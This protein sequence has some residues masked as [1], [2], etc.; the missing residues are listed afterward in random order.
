MDGGTPIDNTQTLNAALSTA[1]GDEA[2]TLNGKINLELISGGVALGGDGVQSITVMGG[3]AG[4]EIHSSGNATAYI[5]A[6][7]G[8]ITFKNIVFTG[9]SVQVP[10]NGRGGLSHFM[11]GG[12]VYFENCTFN[13]GVYI[14]EHADARG[15]NTIA[16]FKSCEF[17]A[18]ANDVYDVWISNGDVTFDDCRFEGARAVKIHE[19]INEDDPY[20][21]DA[22]NSVAFNNCQFL[23]ISLSPALSIGTVK[24]HDYK[25]DGQTKITMTD[26]V[27]KGCQE[28]TTSGEAGEPV[29]GFESLYEADVHTTRYDENVDKPVEFTYTVT[30]DGV[31]Y[32][33]ANAEDFESISQ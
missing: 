18:G 25:Q 2:Y 20:Q 15:V 11:F 19:N 32:R 31:S 12:E 6:K 14:G 1:T 16:E 22:V 4:A 26:C 33:N 10:S 27:V 3:T 28:W 30:L 5:Y 21:S 23:N 13:A 9:D 7:N 17:N 29:E 8:S 24:T